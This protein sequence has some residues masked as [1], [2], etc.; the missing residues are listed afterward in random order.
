MKTDEASVK[1]LSMCIGTAR[2]RRQMGGME[3]GRG[4]RR[5]GGKPPWFYC[6]LLGSP[7]AKRCTLRKRAMC[8]G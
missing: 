2:E 8:C 1:K 7:A 4:E 6:H 5:E 3:A